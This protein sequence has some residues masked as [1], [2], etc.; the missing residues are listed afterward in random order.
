VNLK[1]GTSRGLNAAAAA[2]VLAGLM[3]ALAMPPWPL[4]FLAP[5]GIALWL[6]ALQGD[7]PP[8]RSGLLFGFAFAGPALFW[9][10]WV[11]VPG[12]VALVLIS[13]AEYGLLA[14]VYKRVQARVG[15]GAALWAFAALWPVLERLRAAG[16]I[17]F[18]W[19]NLAHTQLDYLWL[20]QFVEYTGDYGLSLWV[21]V[22]GVLVYA[23]ARQRSARAALAAL[24][25]VALPTIWGAWR[26]S[27]LPPAQRSVEVAIVQGD[28]D[29]YRK[30]DDG[31]VDTSFT[32]YD[33]LS[34]TVT[35]AAELIIWP[36]THGH[37]R[38]GADHLAGDG[39]AD[40]F[41]AGT[42]PPRLGHRAGS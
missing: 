41:D 27:H 4:G 30:W 12:T 26:V 2:A 40:L 18:P 38:R 20:Y 6:W 35:D 32:V 3:E 5:L 21:V 9:I 10:G 17:G 42:L 11:T 33:S 1:I 36:E 37:G 22:C 7:T 39:G 8:F 19:L 24:L 34:R 16:L 14:V 13:A 23:A 28:I 15:R 31:Y 29:T 25:W